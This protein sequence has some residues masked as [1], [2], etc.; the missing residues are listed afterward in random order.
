MIVVDEEWVVQVL[1]CPVVLL[2]SDVAAC[3]GEREAKHVP[4]SAGEA[5]VAAADCFG[6]WALEAS[7]CAFDVAAKAV[8]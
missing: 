7:E 3:D 6:F 4:S 2:V 8:G 5:G 1:A